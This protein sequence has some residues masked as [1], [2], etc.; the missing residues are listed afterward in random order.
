MRDG[1]AIDYGATTEQNSGIVKRLS[2]AILGALGFLQFVVV[3][4]DARHALLLSS[5]TPEYLLRNPP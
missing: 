2:R 5:R 4:G 1:F 3:V